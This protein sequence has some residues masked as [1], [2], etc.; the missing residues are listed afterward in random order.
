MQTTAHTPDSW[1]PGR[2]QARQ[3][4]KRQTISPTAGPLGR[5]SKC[6]RQPTSSTAGAPAGGGD[7]SKQSDFLKGGIGVAG[8]AL[9]VFVALGHLA[10]YL[11]CELAFLSFVPLRARSVVEVGGLAVRVVALL[12]Q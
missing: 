10:L 2:H 3:K 1:T 4:C 8:R 7:R 5:R 6:K 12:N 9:A 11:C